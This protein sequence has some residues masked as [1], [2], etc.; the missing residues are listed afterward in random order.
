MRAWMAAL[1]VSATITMGGIARADTADDLR[2]GYD[3]YKAGEF[4]AAADAFGKVID[5]GN[6]DKDSLAV[7]YNNRGVALQQLGEY[8]AAIADYLRAKDIKPDDPTTQR[9]LRFAYVT[10]G[11][12]NASLG[13]PQKGLEDYDRAL[14][15]DPAYVL[16][17]QRRGT[18]LAELGRTEQATADFELILSLEPGNP[19]ATA[20]LRQLTPKPEALEAPEPAPAAPVPAPRAAT[21]PAATADITP[22]PAP[23]VEPNAGPE[24]PVAKATPSAPTP[25]DPEPAPTPPPVVSAQPAAPSASNVAPNGNWTFRANSSV[26][27]RGGP[28]NDFPRVGGLAAGQTVTADAEKLG[29][30]RIQNDASGEGWVYKRWLDAA[31]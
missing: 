17:L 11:Y 2:A 9:N 3:A 24:P 29:W 26:N 18:L 25:P 30:Y 6:L 19:V 1:L 31:P 22:E 12:T 15:I 27:V 10:R 23:P 4:Q 21:P 20:A 8:D 28:G 13:D 5:T 7:T 16:A 14:N